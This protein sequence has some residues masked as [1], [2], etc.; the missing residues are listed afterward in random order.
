MDTLGRPP[1]LFEMQKHE[2]EGR[3]RHE[4][5]DFQGAFWG[6]AEPFIFLRLEGWRWKGWG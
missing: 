6:C 4:N 5:Q 1:L 2:G 3:E